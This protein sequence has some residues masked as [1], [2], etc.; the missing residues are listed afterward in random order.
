MNNSMILIK[1]NEMLEARGKT[2]YWLS[3]VAGIPHVTVW[4]LSRKKSQSSINLSVLS[5]ICTAL[6][7][8]PGDLLEYL[9]D[10]E[11]RA[12]AT[13]VEAQA[14]KYGTGKAEKKPVKKRSTAK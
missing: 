1:L 14:A 4:N 12:I 8:L 10:V 7:C 6:N 9:P 13:L 5:R 2:V 3:R 11:D